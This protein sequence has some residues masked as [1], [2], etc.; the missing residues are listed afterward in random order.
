MINPGF[1]EADHR[2]KLPLLFT[3]YQGHL[4]L[5]W[6]ITVDFNLDHLAEIIWHLSRVS[7]VKCS[8]ILP[9][10]TLSSLEGSH[11]EQP[12]KGS[13]QLCASSLRMKRL[14]KLFGILLLRRFVSFPHLCT[15]SNISL[16]QYG[17]MDIYLILQVIMQYWFL[18]I[19]QSVPA[20]PLGALSLGPSAPL[21]YS[22]LLGCN[23]DFFAHVCKH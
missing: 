8:F 11:C 3:S 10:L 16:C 19:A 21:T 18:F 17:L 7:S 20:L 13:G 12:T 6:S 23:K 2:D 9:P 14:H 22:S 5:T 15:C 4:V 1:G